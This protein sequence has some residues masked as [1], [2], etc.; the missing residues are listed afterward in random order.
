M[1]LKAL[2]LPGI[3]GKSMVDFWGDNLL[4]FMERDM[5]LSR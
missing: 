3:K 4:H 5:I 1:W 2:K